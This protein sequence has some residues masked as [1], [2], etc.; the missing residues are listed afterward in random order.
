MI[1]GHLLT[2]EIFFGA[3]ICFVI[4]LG[5]LGVGKRWAVRPEWFLGFGF[6]VVLVALGVCISDFLNPNFENFT[7]YRGWIGKGTDLRGI[8]VGFF[9]D[10][11][12]FLGGLVTVIFGIVLL[13]NR[14]ALGKQQGNDKVYAALGFCVSGVL[15]A[16]VALTPW[17]IFVGTAIVIFGSFLCFGSNWE[18]SE[19][20][21]R[22]ASRIAWEHSS[23]LVIALVG[24]C[25]LANSGT[26]VRFDQMGAFD[27]GGSRSEIQVGAFLMVLGA[28]FQ[29]RSFPF[30]AGNILESKASVAV[31]LGVAQV[32]QTRKPL[33]IGS[34]RMK[35][36]KTRNHGRC[37]KYGNL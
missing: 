32:F 22:F 36:D 29:F 16:W 26:S 34:C 14:T 20:E 12:S 37:S 25:I 23:A 11:S 27:S 2:G 6:L 17:M 33:K 1:E 3:V 18:E 31:R 7:L 21:A 5:L 8:S 9:Q 4:S 13:V 30:L 10:G 24:G 28:L 35:P 19:E 15:I